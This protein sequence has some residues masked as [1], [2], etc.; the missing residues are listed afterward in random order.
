MFWKAK[1]RDHKLQAAFRTGPYALGKAQL[2]VDCGTFAYTGDEQKETDR[3][4]SKRPC[5][6]C[7][8][9]GLLSEALPYFR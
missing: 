2:W 8:S 7:L 3:N 1:Q 6:Q 9:S 4:T 5:S